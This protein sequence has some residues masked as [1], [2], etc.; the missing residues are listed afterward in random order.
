[1]DIVI[2]VIGTG[3]SPELSNVLGARLVHS[4]NAVPGE[5]ASDTDD[6][7]GHGTAVISL[8]AALAPTAKIVSIKTFSREGTGSSYSI[9]K[10]ILLAIDEGAK[11]ILLPFGS[12]TPDKALES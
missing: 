6:Q 2:A 1:G 9:V 10:G 3:I 11:V 12:P 4:S 7:S 8:V 5:S